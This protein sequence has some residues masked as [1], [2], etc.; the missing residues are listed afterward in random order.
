M[1]SASI[2]RT[3]G[4][5]FHRMYHL[6]TLT[7]EK[8]NYYSVYQFV[9]LFPMDICSYKG[10]TGEVID[11]NMLFLSSSKILYS[12]RDV[13]IAD[14]RLQNPNLCSALMTFQRNLYRVLHSVT[15]IYRFMRKTTLCKLFL[16]QTSGH[17]Y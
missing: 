11:F 3:H 4:H 13:H 1:C 9:Y 12:Y 14:E 10:W 17:I 2:Y 7:T 5:N 8:D 15:R 6:H 16:Q